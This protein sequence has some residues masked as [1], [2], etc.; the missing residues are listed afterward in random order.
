MICGYTYNRLFCIIIVLAV[1]FVSIVIGGYTI[2]GNDMYS[3][4]LMSLGNS[5][6][7]YVAIMLVSAHLIVGFLIIVNPVSQFFE[8]YLMEILSTNNRSKLDL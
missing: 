2:Y 3:N 8:E 4:L 1:L 7:S 6:M 5:W